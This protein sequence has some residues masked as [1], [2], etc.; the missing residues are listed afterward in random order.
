MKT[1]IITGLVLFISIIISYCQ[2][3]EE[4]FQEF[5]FNFSP[6]GARAAAM[7]KAFIGLADDT[8]AA[9]TNPAGL[10]T[11]LTPEFSVEYKGTNTIIKRFATVNSLINKIPSDFGDKTNSISFMLLLSF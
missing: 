7:G 5:K 2:T 8:T 9:E 6:P 10:T 3:D 1:I 11:L 4:I